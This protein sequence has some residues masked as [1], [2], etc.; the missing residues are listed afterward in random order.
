MRFFNN[1]TPADSFSPLTAAGTTGYAEISE[2]FHLDGY[3]RLGGALFLSMGLS[4]QYD[5]AEPKRGAG[6]GGSAG[7]AKAANGL[8]G[9]SRPDC[10]GRQV[11]IA[12]N[13]DTDITT[14]YAAYSHFAGVF[15]GLVATSTGGYG[16]NMPKNTIT[17]SDDASPTN[18]FT[19]LGASTAACIDPLNG[20]RSYAKPGDIICVRR[21][22][23]VV[24]WASSLNS[25]IALSA[26]GFTG[27]ANTPNDGVLTLTAVGTIVGVTITAP[28]AFATTGAEQGNKIILT[29]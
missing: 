9:L 17:A 29:H 22:G 8:D 27:A 4:V 26:V 20:G 25:T 19:Y 14:L 1:G 13:E 12:D 16:Y 6:G 7:A 10:F 18:G 28:T 21:F 23:P 3:V 2:P 24:G 11:V 15:T 5:S